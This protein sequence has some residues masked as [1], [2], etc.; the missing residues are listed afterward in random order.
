MCTLQ[1]EDLIQDE[2]RGRGIECRNNTAPGFP[3]RLRN[4]GREI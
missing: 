3:Q 1:C 4:R 2:A